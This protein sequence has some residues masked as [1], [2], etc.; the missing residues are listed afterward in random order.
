VATLEEIRPK[1]EPVESPEE[2]S[3]R[4]EEEHRDQ[5]TAEMNHQL[6]A[7]YKTLSDMLKSQGHPDLKKVQ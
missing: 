1:R 4:L 6:E 2:A 5:V 7:A 3:L